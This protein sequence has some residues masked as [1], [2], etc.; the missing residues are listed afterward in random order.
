MHYDYFSRS[1]S[2]SAGLKYNDIIYIY[3]GNGD[4]V[5]LNLNSSDYGY[6]PSAGKITVL[7]NPFALT[8]EDADAVVS[9][10]QA[11]DFFIITTESELRSAVQTDGINIKLDN[12]IDLSNKT[13]EIVGG[14]TVTIDLGGHTLDRKLTN[15]GEGGGQVITVRKGATLH[16]SNGTLQ[17]GW[18]GNGGGFTFSNTLDK[19]FTKIKVT[20]AS[21]LPGWE[22]N[23]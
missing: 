12:D 17:G 22:V 18:G 10:S 14:T 2:G 9:A 6:T 16:L 4:V 5:S 21:S 13:L 23:G 15:R 1:Y 20:T 11:S 3:G 7:T 8:M 19:N